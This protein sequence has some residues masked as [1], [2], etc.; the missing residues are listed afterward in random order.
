MSVEAGGGN[1]SISPAL[2]SISLFGICTPYRFGM[3]K[4][5][6]D[7]DNKVSFVIWIFDDYSSFDLCKIINTKYG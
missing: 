6:F 2:I 1:E 4:T 3:T 5:T 7:Q